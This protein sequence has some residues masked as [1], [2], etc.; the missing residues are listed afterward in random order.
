MS[1]RHEEAARELAAWREDAT[2]A[3][4]RV[5]VALLRFDHAFFRCGTADGRQ[6]RRS[7]ATDLDPV[8]RDELQARCLCLDG[9]PA[10]PRV[11]VKRWSRCP[12]TS[13]ARGPAWTPSSANA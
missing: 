10:G 9:W 5:R 12:E 3:S 8:W 7:S 11:V 2:D 13:G 4:E 1:G 6:L